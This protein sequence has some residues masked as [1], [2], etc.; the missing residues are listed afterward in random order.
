MGV[1]NL[2]AVIQDHAPK[3]IKRNEIKSYFGRKVAIDASMSIYQF[4]IAV[5]QQ[6]G[7]QLMNETGE[8]TS[9]LMG[10]FYR[11][12]RMVDN[13]LKPCY[14]FDGSPPKLKSGEL[15]KRFARRKEA[16][17]NLADAKEEAEASNDQT[18]VDKFSRRTV[19]VTKEQNEEVKRLLRL[20]GIPVVTAPCE[21]EAQCAA[22][23]K[24]GRVYAAGSEDMDT[25]TFGAPVVLRHLTFSEQRKVPIDEL[26]FDATLQGLEM[27]H[28]QFV[29]MCILLGC[30][31]CDPIKG[32]GPKRAH[33]LI[34]KYKTIE[35]A[36][37]TLDKT[38]H[39][40]P[41]DWPYDSA[42]ELFL[43]ADVADPNTIELDFNQKPDIEGLVQ[44]LVTE[45]GFNEDRV[46][47]GAA[48][49][50]K[51]AGTAQQGRLDGFFKPV[52]GTTPPKRK[53]DEKAKPGKKQKVATGKG[54]K[55]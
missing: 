5:R 10:M 4:L 20:M 6:D 55:K 46:R 17:T 15:A 44:Y 37:E 29:D 38:K 30:D 8:T 47:G 11:T 53:A 22:L 25:L 12:I 40:I 24:A 33:E 26:H 41:D 31:Y 3:A 27:T 2:S 9:H 45:K 36:I 42:R 14:V 35:A 19:R 23:A 48:K 34:S 51:A 7:Q 13:G 43:K 16:E 1:K 54:K 28:E 49:L 32:I 18:Q 52:P 50:L 39:P 21:A